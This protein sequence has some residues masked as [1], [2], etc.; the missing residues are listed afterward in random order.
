MLSAGSPDEGFAYPMHHPK[1]IFSED[2]LTQGAAVYA[3][4][5]L[6]WLDSQ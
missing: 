1:A 4:S 5:A 6:G 2:V 3:I